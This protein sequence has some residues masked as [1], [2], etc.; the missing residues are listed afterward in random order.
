MTG[1]FYCGKCG[2]L[3][4]DSEGDTR[5]F[6]AAEHQP[7]PSCGGSGIRAE[8][9]VEKKVTCFDQMSMK[10]KDARGTSSTMKVGGS[11]SVDG[12]VAHIEQVVDKR[13]R[14]Y[15]KKV[16]LTDGTVVKDVEGPLDDQSLHGPQKKDD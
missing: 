15:K 10:A 8:V 9:T 16:T 12:T 4:F 7:C 1:T 3:L 2:D 13:A 6:V 5:R 11:L 14:T